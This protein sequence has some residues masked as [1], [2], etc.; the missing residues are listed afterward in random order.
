[1]KHLQRKLS[2]DRLG[3]LIGLLLNFQKVALRFSRMLNFI[4]QVCTLAFKEDE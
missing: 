3:F 2:S 4:F 1:M